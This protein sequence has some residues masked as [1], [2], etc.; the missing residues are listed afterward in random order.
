MKHIPFALFFAALASSAVAADLSIRNMRVCGLQAP[1]GIDRTPTFGWQ[2]EAAARGFV[3][4][5]YQIT[6]AD[7]Q[8]REVWNSGAV[9]SRRQSDIAYEGQPLQSCS[10]Y[11]WTLTVTGQDGSQSEPATGTFETAFMQ[12]D[13][14][15]AKWVGSP[16]QPNAQFPVTFDQPLSARYLRIDATR[17]GQPAAT[18]NTGYYMQFAEIEVTGAD[19]GKLSYKATA[20]SNMNYGTIWN[21][22]YLNDGYVGSSAQLGYTTQ[23]FSSPN[24]HVTLTLD[25]GAEKK[26]AGMVLYPRQ[27]DRANGQSD[28][29]ANFP[30]DFKVQYSL[31]GSTYTTEKT[32]TGQLPSFNDNSNNVPYFAKAFALDR[33]VVRARIYASGL[34]VFTLR[35]NGQSVTDARLEPGEAEYEKSI[36]YS[37]YDVTPLLRQGQNTLLAQVAGGIYNVETLPGRYSKGEIKN[38]GQTGLLCE[39]LLEYADGTSERILSDGTW[40]TTPSPTLGSNW[41]GGE[42]YDARRRIADIFSPTPDLSAWQPVQVFTPYFQSTQAKGFGTLRSRM[43]EPVRVVEQWQAV[44]V[45]TTYSGGY[46]L[47]VVDFGRNF[48]GVYRFRLKGKPGQTI[49]LRE[50]ESLNAD[51]SVFMQNYYTGPADTYETYTFRGDAEGEEWGP[52]FMYHGFRYLQIIGLTQAPKPEDFTAMRLRADIANSGTFATSNALLNDI[53][54]I[55]RDAIA[56]QLYNSITDCP[57]REKL[58]WLDVP[59]EMFNSLAYNFD[60]QNFWRKVV[61]DCFDAQLP[62]GRVPSTVPHYMSVYDNDP[63]WGGAAILVPY[64]VWRTYADESLMRQYYPQMKRLMDYYTGETTDGI[65]NNISVLSDWGQETAGV[66]PMVPS[67]FTITTTYYHMLRVMAEMADWLG[68]AGDAEAFRTRAAHT[69]QAF[70]ARYYGAR[71]A[72]EYGHGQQGELAM[73]LYYGLVDEANEADVARRLAERVKADGYKI[74]TGEIALKPLFMS[75]AKYGYNDVVYKMANQTDCPSYGWW[76]KQGYTT[77]P[78][79]WDVGAFSQ[80]HCMMDHIEEWFFSQ[81]GGLQNGGCGYDTLVVKPWLPADMDS[82]RVTAPTPRGTAAV[83]WQRSEEAITYDITVPT[84]AVGVITLPLAQGQRLYEA[85]AQVCEGERGVQRVAYADEGVELTVGSGTYRFTARQPNSTAIAAVA[86]GQAEAGRYYSLQGVAS[87]RPVRGVN[88]H[89]GNKFVAQ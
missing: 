37:T 58:G 8:G 3:Q 88:I 32:Y 72:G 83:A 6:V 13:E 14:W 11:R 69:R 2:T 79:Y 84:G 48:A 21:L 42:D 47:H 60:M 33:Q 71:K 68:H 53:H 18:D 7:A 82:L 41:W 85:D 78:E 77:T 45:R 40:R 46:K 54:I 50:G 67:E 81:L 52:E 16:K 75:L 70:N 20:S 38:A 87:E 51:G 12:S 9:Q 63:N 1:L 29:V 89:S 25:L 43:Y 22:N 28:K 30:S 31:N 61:M 55:C 15:Q 36:L 44:K 24:Q 17:L 19:G 57:Q 66:S 56:S 5:S 39:L 49:T 35:L 65:M 34:G 76:V 64:R 26:V 23:K 27:D 4:Q 80:N 10:A 73:P 59:N 86:Q 62:D 74:K